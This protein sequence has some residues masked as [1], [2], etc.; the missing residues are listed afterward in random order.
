[1]AQGCNI[2]G[3]CVKEFH[4]EPAAAGRETNFIVHDSQ[5]YLCWLVPRFWGFD[6]SPLDYCLGNTAGLPYL[7]R[8]GEYITGYD[9]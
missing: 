1:M 6:L 2:S 9:D 4:I 8:I 3:Y 7:K 5:G